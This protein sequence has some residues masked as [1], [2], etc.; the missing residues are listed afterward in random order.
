M[1]STLWSQ[2]VWVLSGCDQHAGN[3]F[4]M[5][6]NLQNRS[7]IW[8][9]VLSIA[10]E[11]EPKVLDFILWLHYYYFGFLGCFPLSLHFLTSQINTVLWTLGRYRRLK[12]FCKQGGLFP[13]RPCNVLMGF[14][15][16]NLV[17]RP[18]KEYNSFSFTGIYQ[19]LDGK[20]RVN[21][22]HTYAYMH[23][24]THTISHTCGN[25]IYIG[26][27]LT[28][29]IIIPKPVSFFL[30][31]ELVF[32]LALLTPKENFFFFFGLFAFS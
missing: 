10:L 27:R 17:V 7:G 4:L 30:I 16:M 13:G 26:L 23:T 29:R 5:V 24:C 11:E 6:E 8:I 20:T 28:K 21:I 18:P 19:H 32:A 1:S 2:L 9:R 3:F 25:S 12:L 31:R 22:S 14:T 15:C